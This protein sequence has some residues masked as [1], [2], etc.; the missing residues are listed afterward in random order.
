MLRDSQ[1]RRGARRARPRACHRGEVIRLQR[2]A[3]THRE[4]EQEP[5]EHARDANRAIGA[6][7]PARRLGSALVRTR[8]TPGGESANRLV[9]LLGALERLPGGRETTARAARRSARSPRSPSCP[10]LARAFSIVSTISRSAAALLVRGAVH[11]LRHVL[12]RDRLLEHEVVALLL[13]ARGRA[14]SARP[15]RRPLR[16]RPPRE[17]PPWSARAP[18]A[19]MP[20]T[21]FLLLRAT[22]VIS[23]SER[24]ACSGQVDALRPRSSC[25]ARSRRPRWC[26]RPAPSGS[27]W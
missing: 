11:L 13:V 14:R 10:S 23:I 1:Q 27:G 19:S 26:S 5:R 16:S 24:P 6:L 9:V 22:R 8:S 17:S 21:S 25:R 12:H 20:S 7:R 18:T 4:A 3:Q 15:A 2:V